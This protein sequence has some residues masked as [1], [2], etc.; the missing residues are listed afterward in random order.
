MGCVGWRQSEL[1]PSRKS[2]GM[3]VMPILCFCLLFG[4]PLAAPDNACRGHNR[5]K[6]QEKSET[7]GLGGNELMER[8]KEE[9]K[10]CKERK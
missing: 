4:V 9:R 6:K 5:S 2:V 10:R 8:R 1:W 3:A 7:S